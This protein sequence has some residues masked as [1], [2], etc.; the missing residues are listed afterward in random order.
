LRPGAGWYSGNGLRVTVEKSDK[1]IA[2]PE[3][4]PTLALIGCTLTIDAIAE[5]I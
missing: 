5:V 3:L 1:I 4:L 2:I